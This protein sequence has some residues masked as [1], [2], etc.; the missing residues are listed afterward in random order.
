[1][2]GEML[3][4]KQEI[5]IWQQSASRLSERVPDEQ[6]VKERLTGHIVQLEEQLKDA[7]NQVSG[8][9][10]DLTELEK[11]YVIRDVPL[12]ALCAIILSAVILMF[13]LETFINQWV[14][15][16]LDSIALIGAFSVI[17]LSD[18]KHFDHVLEKVEWSSLLFF[19]TLFIM[20]GALSRLGLIDFVGDSVTSAILQVPE[21]AR[22]PVAITI[23][24]WLSAIVSAIIDSIPYTTAMIP[25]I[26]AM[27]D[28]L[29]LPLKPLVFSLAYGTGLGGNGSIIGST[30]N[31]VVAG[32]SSKAGYP[33]SFLYFSKNG[34]PIMLLSTAIS[35]V[36]L[37]FVHC[38][39]G[40]GMSMPQ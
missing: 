15:F 18:T 27:A 37:L 29:R 8:K 24:V 12:F 39:F 14:H 9:K 33:I 40:L 16:S 32:L 22:L 31:L 20:M 11:E 34:I 7:Y 17:V 2:T 19:A 30:A 6:V 35:N 3:Q 23:I 26:L 28:N 21:N 25:V 5:V 4:I 13:F 10:V 38:V 36:Y 1:M